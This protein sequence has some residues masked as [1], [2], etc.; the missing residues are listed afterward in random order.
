MQFF[1]QKQEFG[2]TFI[3]QLSNIALIRTAFIMLTVVSIPHAELFGKS[4]DSLLKE[5]RQAY[6]MGNGGKSLELYDSAQ[7]YFQR[8]NNKRGEL[9]ALYHQTRYLAEE[10]GS[11]FD[12]VWRPLHR[13]S[14]QLN[15]LPNIFSIRASYYRQIHKVSTIED[16]T[17]FKRSLKQL[18]R[19]K[20]LLDSL[21][22]SYPE[23][24]IRINTALGF[25]YNALTQS[26][27]GFNFKAYK[28]MKN[29]EIDRVELKAK[30]Y[31]Y[32]TRTARYKDD[33]DSSIQ[34]LKKG[35]KVLNNRVWEK[36]RL[37]FSFYYLIGKQL[38]SVKKLSKA[39]KY[40][41]SA[42]RVL[43]ANDAIQGLKGTQVHLGI[44]QIHQNKLRH[45][46]ALLHHRKA[47]DLHKASENPNPLMAINIYRFLSLV[48]GE[49]NNH[50]KAIRFAKKGIEIFKEHAKFQRYALIRSTLFKR[51]GEN[52]K[53]Q[54]LPKK[55]IKQFRKSLKV[56]K[57]YP[58]AQNETIG[59]NYADLGMIYY[60][61]E[62]YD[63]ALKSFEQAENYLRKHEGLSKNYL[64]AQTYYNEAKVHL[65]KGKFDSALNK[66]E[67]CF[68][69]NT[70]GLKEEY[71]DYPP[72]QYVKRFKYAFLFATLKA[73]IYQKQYDEQ[74]DSTYLQ[75]ALKGYEHA[76]RY[77]KQLQ[78]AN[79]LGKDPM[80]IAKKTDQV[81]PPA[82]EVVHEM[83][84]D[85][86][87]LPDQVRK[88]YLNKA[89]RFSER[90][91]ATLLNNQM[92]K[93]S[94]DR[95]DYLPDS[96]VNK[97]QTLNQE[98]EKLLNATKADKQAN[99][100]F[101][102]QRLAILNQK[103]EVFQEIE[104]TFPEFYNLKFNQSI[105]P[106]SE[107]QN[108]LKKNK[109]NLVEY[110]YDGNQLFALVVTPEGKELV[111]LPN[112]DGLERPI[113][114]IRTHLKNKGHQFHKKAAHQIYET[115]FKPIQS[116][117]T[118]E[119]LV[120]VPDGV[121]GKLP[122]GM[123]LKSLP[124]K[125]NPSKYPFLIKDYAFSYAPSASLWFNAESAQ[126]HAKPDYQ[127]TF[128]GFGPDFK[129]ES[130]KIAKK[131]YRTAD[132][133]RS[134]LGAI[135]GAKKELAQSAK[136]WNSEVFTGEQAKESQFKKHAPSSKIIHLATHGII[137]EHN[138]AYSKLMF[139][140]DSTTAEDGMLHNYEIHQMD[141]NAD[142]AVLSACRT[143]FG[144]LIDG[145]GLMSMARSFKI[146]GC[147]NIMMTLWPV[148]DRSTSK[149]MQN[150]YQNLNKGLDKENALRQA[151]LEYLDNTNSIG[152]NPFY[153]AGFVMMGS[154]ADVEI[155]DHQQSGSSW[156]LVTAGGLLF[157]IISVGWIW[158]RKWR[159]TTA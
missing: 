94:L 139:T 42:Y 70:V 126:D 146:A 60:D 155:T 150:F 41:D 114:Q 93:Y 103:Q 112:K 97:L 19:A 159:G 51:L 62:K 101:Q 56:L 52:Y 66:I 68:N 34:L 72:E 40:Y 20:H 140:S 7:G 137:D 33:V 147:K 59:K 10:S 71:G 1:S 32:L 48:H 25:I 16:K 154:S 157:I 116:R 2:N 135:P 133:L 43:K 54:K 64:A 28:V 67:K 87:T 79:I 158:M 58:Y 9:K 76:D 131:R 29:Y 122:F 107:I 24:R 91:R 63:S 61:L 69:S 31:Q 134:R 145:E 45:H 5:A 132:T 15:K 156:W 151:K 46:K 65:A 27:K 92:A 129:G 55:A 22:K 30:T 53:A 23:D 127:M 39:K 148:E 96:L 6:L 12:S 105:V 113:Q 75:K 152:S 80:I 49:L 86:E 26:H 119:E 120:I 141:L 100:K 124:E 99:S 143:G 36:H 111:E 125:A 13:K 85:F 4:G 38:K 83:L 138:P 98:K 142:L 82:I 153:W 95:N 78:T 89:Y 77:L 14:Q 104:E 115:L 149:L 37:Y 3:K 130:Q 117:L 84:D 109:A 136:L 88:T 123:L 17:V 108:Q 90:N 8:N 110:S 81:Y 73:S 35:I 74:K 128:T 21:E 102:N 118:S 47:Y 57:A 50:E 11:K 121:L 18:K 144:K 44:G 106:L